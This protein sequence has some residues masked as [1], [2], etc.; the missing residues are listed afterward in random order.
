MSE[1]QS[2]LGTPVSRKTVASEMTRQLLPNPHPLI[3]AGGPVCCF[4]L[5]D[6]SHHQ[7]AYVSD[8]LLA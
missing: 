3:H 5:V 1:A 8:S 4:V 6:L 2:P 7:E